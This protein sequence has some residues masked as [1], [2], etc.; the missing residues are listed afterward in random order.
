MENDRKKMEVIHIGTPIVTKKRHKIS[1]WR[2]TDSD[3]TP[4]GKKFKKS[5][6]EQE[7]EIQVLIAKGIL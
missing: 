6:R 1:S 7:R 4:P 5:L 3:V 2:L